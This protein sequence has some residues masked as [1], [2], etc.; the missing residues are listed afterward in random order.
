MRKFLYNLLFPLCI[1]SIL[2]GC[3]IAIS[4]NRGFYSWQY[5]KNDAP[6]FTGLSLEDLD[7]VTDNLL[8]YLVGARDNLDMQA[9]VFGEAREVFDEREKAHMIDVQRLYINVLYLELALL[10]AV[11]LTLL[12]ILAP[13]NKEGVKAI[14]FAKYKLVLGGS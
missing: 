2:L 8:D 3:I 4:L 10:A 7:V 13:K 12:A 6:L 11:A 14:L 1:V 5:E 9:E